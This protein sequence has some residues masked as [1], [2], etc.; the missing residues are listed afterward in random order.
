MCK[1]RRWLMSVRRSCGC[2]GSKHR[3]I[4]KALSAELGRDARTD[5]GVVLGMLR[6][7]RIRWHKYTL[8]AHTNSST[9]LLECMVFS[10]L[11]VADAPLLRVPTWTP[12]IHSFVDF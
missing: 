2:W 3:R 9:F 11:V 6:S 4:S 12:T 7:P 8:A 5:D 10:R 1:P